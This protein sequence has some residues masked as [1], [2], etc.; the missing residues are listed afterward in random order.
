MPLE[1]LKE[2]EKGRRKDDEKKGGREDWL[3]GRI[4]MCFRLY[5]QNTCK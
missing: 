3:T 5:I 4:V 2:K 1:K